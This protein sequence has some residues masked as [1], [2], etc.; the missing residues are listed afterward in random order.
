MGTFVIPFAMFKFFYINNFGY[1]EFKN[2]RTAVH[3]LSQPLLV[4]YHLIQYF[5]TNLNPS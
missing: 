3:T 5:R 1:Y 4:K 2:F